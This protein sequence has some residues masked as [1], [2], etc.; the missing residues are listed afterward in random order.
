MHD[1]GL[2]NLKSMVASPSRGEGSKGS[3]MAET[4]IDYARRRTAEE[5]DR[6][7]RCSDPDAAQVHRRLAVLYANMVAEL[8]QLTPCEIAEQMDMPRATRREI[9]MPQRLTSMG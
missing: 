1:F 8:H 5:L 9:P 6:A 4:E 7:D 2:K 3:E